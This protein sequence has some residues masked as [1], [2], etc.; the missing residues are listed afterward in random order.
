MKLRDGLVLAVVMLT[1]VGGAYWMGT[2]KG[3]GTVGEAPNPS[4]P[5]GLIVPA[6][7]GPVPEPST[8]PIAKPTE[9]LLGELKTP[10]DL[11]QAPAAGKPAEFVVPD[12]GRDFG[13]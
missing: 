1:S 7:L 9:V 8:V 3:R 4:N 5:H 2:Q 12:L 11:L 10:N 6:E 13:R